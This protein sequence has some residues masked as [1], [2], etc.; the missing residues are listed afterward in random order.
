MVR[1]A[2]FKK[3]DNYLKLQKSYKS[4]DNEQHVHKIQLN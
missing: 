2:L 4:D 3:L 1:I